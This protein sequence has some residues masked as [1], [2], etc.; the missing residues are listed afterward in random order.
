MLPVNNKKECRILK[1]IPQRPR[2]SMKVFLTL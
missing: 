2:S 1:I